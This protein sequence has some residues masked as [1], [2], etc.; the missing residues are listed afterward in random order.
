MLLAFFS[1]QFLN[2]K[3]N[4]IFTFFKIFDMLYVNFYLGAYYIE[5]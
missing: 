3:K 4:Q 1:S 5:K 2:I